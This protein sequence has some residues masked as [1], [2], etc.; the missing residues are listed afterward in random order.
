MTFRVNRA[1]ALIKSGKAATRGKVS[2]IGRLPLTAEKAT[3][4]EDDEIFQLRTL[5][6]QE[7][8]LKVLKA[9]RRVD[10]A[11]LS[12]ELTELLKVNSIF[13]IMKDNMRLFFKPVIF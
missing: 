11:T 7:A 2:L 8:A 13:K 1:F 12:S 5:R 9:R 10:A 6:V 3:K 4:K